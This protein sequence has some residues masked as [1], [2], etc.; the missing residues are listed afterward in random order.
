[1]ANVLINNLPSRDNIINVDQ[2]VY[3]YAQSLTP[4]ALR[5]IE[6]KN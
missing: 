6:Y 1:M 4:L 3:F 2:C 5:M